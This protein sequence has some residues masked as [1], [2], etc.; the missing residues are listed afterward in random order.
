M[1]CP[2]CEVPSPPHDEE[3]EACV[4]GSMILDNECIRPVLGLLGAA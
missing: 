1:T 4:L 2:S 3:A